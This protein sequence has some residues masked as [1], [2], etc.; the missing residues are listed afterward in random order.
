MSDPLFGRRCKLT[1]A[2]PVSTPGDFGH[3]TSQLV[4]INAADEQQGLRVQFKITKTR[5]KE[6]NAGEVTITNLSETRRKSLGAKG[7]KLRLEAGY[8][9]TGLSLIFLG[10]ARTID[11]RREGP[12]WTTTIKAGDGERAFRWARASESF[13]E[14]TAASKIVKYLAEQLGVDKGN[15]ATEADQISAKFDQGY[16]VVGSA[17]QSMD[18]LLGSL[19][20]GWSIQDGV[21]QI[22]RTDD[23]LRGTIIPEISPETGLIGSP[24][25]G[26]S[27]KKGGGG[28]IK[29]KAL[30]FPT[31]PGKRVKL[32]S[33][34]YDGEVTVKRA[35]FDG[36]TEA[37]PW[38]TEIEGVIH[39]K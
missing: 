13:A 34:R 21:L 17:Q 36:D 33:A 3:T 18:R 37:G 24:E 5:E 15:A 19:G 27:E 29:F 2:I 20:Y 1:L 32:R 22:L 8:A 31:A 26:T 23:Y 10:D 4:E 39:A 7:V 11:H 12:D 9:A 38:Y 28:L 25:V 6:P 35:V 30:L 14:G 16:V